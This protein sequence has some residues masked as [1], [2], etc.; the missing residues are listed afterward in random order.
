MSDFKTSYDAIVLIFSWGTSS[1]LSY[2]DII[3]SRSILLLKTRKERESDGAGGGGGGRR[4]EGEGVGG[5]LLTPL[6][7]VVGSG[8]KNTSSIFCACLKL[9]QK[10]MARIIVK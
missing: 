1:S 2:Y 5:T 7:T 9:D 10:H 3:V 4:R 6:C 8:L